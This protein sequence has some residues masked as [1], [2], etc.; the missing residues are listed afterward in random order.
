MLSAIGETKSCPVCGA[1]VRIH[2]GMFVRHDAPTLGCGGT[3]RSCG[4]SGLPL[5]ICDLCKADVHLGAGGFW[6]GH[7]DSRDCPVTP[8]GHTVGGEP[9]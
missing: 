1:P 7:D 2:H 8:E 6:V 3:D 9:R 4:G 5:L